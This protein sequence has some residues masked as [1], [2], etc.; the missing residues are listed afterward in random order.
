MVSFKES[1]VGVAISDSSIRFIELIQTRT[2]IRVG[3]WGER[4]IPEGIV[5]SGDIK[6]PEK[7]THILTRFRR[8]DGFSSIHIA[9]P[10]RYE[11]LFD[12]AVPQNTKGEA[13]TD[14]TSLLE[15]RTPMKAKDAVVRHEAFF[16]ADAK[17]QYRIVMSACA[18][19]DV[20]KYTNI[21]TQAGLKPVSF[22]GE[23]HARVRAIVPK[24]DLKTHMIVSIGNDASYIAVVT[25]G[26]VRFVAKSDVGGRG[27]KD[28]LKSEYPDASS[29]EIQR[30]LNE[31][32]EA[33]SVLEAT[34]ALISSL[35]ETLIQ[36][37]THWRDDIDTQ[38][39]IETVLLCG[40][41]AA[42]AGLPEHLS[43]EIELPVSYADVWTNVFST[44][45]HV[46]PIG[47][48]RSL[49]FAEAI[50]LALRGC[51]NDRK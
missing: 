2:G 35:G 20:E 25:R 41:Y 34:Q 3:R 9:L 26:V 18:Q 27:I 1:S 42:I 39:E 31:K 33:D 4:Y 40:E 44:H 14:F 7:L 16:D 36:Y 47:R 13:K 5:V 23:V 11:Y 22:E 45:E 6:Q 50:G 19:K 21:F 43:Q 8:N 32:T 30:M 15:S 29:Q 37:R 51:R 12:S 46:P 24:S 38:A 48:A 17:K 49:G 10:Q 28:A